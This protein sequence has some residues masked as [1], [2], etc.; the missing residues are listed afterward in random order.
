MPE[1]P[2]VSFDQLG[3]TEEEDDV[4]SPVEE[5]T[6]SGQVLWSS[7]DDEKIVKS[8]LH[9]R[10]GDKVGVRGCDCDTIIWKGV[11]GE[12]EAMQ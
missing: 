3:T 11:P 1:V 10:V 4:L 8:C 9:A 2:R 12:T 7:G 5:R 6:S